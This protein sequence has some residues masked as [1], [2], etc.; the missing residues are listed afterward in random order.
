MLSKDGI[1]YFAFICVLFFKVRRSMDST[2][3]NY[4]LRAV[5]EKVYVCVWGWGYLLNLVLMEAMFNRS[6][7]LQALR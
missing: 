7:H 3:F 6:L 4:I 5:Q 1:Q 2:V